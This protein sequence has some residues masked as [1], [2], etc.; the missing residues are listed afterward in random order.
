METSLDRWAASGRPILISGL[1]LLVSFGV[2]A[3]AGTPTPHAGGG[4]RHS[5]RPTSNAPV[6]LASCI[7]SMPPA[8]M[9]MFQAGGM[10]LPQ[11]VGFSAGVVQGNLVFGQESQA[12]SVGLWIAQL[13][14]ATGQLSRIAPLPAGAAGVGAMAAALPWVVWQEGDSQYQQSDWSIHAWNQLSGQTETLAT[15]QARAGGF[16]TGQPPAPVVWSGLASWAQP[17]T[18]GNYDL[19]L[20]DLSR[21]SMRTLA[22]GKLSSPVIAGPYLIWAEQSAAGETYFHAMYTSTLKPAPLPPALRGPQ[23]VLYLAGSGRYLAWSNSTLNT[24][25]VWRVGSAHYDA[26][27]P[28][29]PNF[30]SPNFQF[31]QI[32]GPYVLWYG[33]YAPLAIDIRTGRGFLVPHGLA[34]LVGNEG[35][36]VGGGPVS[37]LPSSKSVPGSFTL[38]LVRVATASVPPIPACAV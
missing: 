26:F 17:T 37:A 12:T 7:G 9:S 3:C 5:V 34:A 20:A 16:V 19:D 23:S 18:G 33:G 11:G 31:L 8:W 6:T 32:A 15:S 14:F 13:N 21:G 25:M 29:V 30:G 28:T 35:W 27:A 36:I 22:S 1:L 2:A 4:T 10:I 38:R 24:L